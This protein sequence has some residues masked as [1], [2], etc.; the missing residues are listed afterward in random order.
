M[1]PH[2]QVVLGYSVTQYPVWYMVLLVMIRFW[3]Q[4]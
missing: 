3:A 1:V 2:Q 4:P